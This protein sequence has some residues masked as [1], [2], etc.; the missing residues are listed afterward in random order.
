MPWVRCA[1][2]NV[3]YLAGP[4]KYVLRKQTVPEENDGLMGSGYVVFCSNSNFVKVVYGP[5]A[6]SETIP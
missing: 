1:F 6:N 2:G 4:E 3:S 5:C